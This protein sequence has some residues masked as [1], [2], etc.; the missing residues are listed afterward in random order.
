MKTLKENW[1]L[2]NCRKALK[3]LQNSQFLTKNEIFN[4]NAHKILS[5]VYRNL[6]LGF[7]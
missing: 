2:Q 3:K 7:Q 1:T 5:N 4:K 6:N